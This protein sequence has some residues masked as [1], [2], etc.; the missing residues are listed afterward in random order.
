MA[1][2]LSVAGEGVTLIDNTAQRLRQNPTA[3]EIRFW[4]LIAPLRSQWHFRKQVRMGPYFVDF[5]SHPAK[6]VIEIDGDTHY[7]G[8]GPERDL[9]RDKALS[10]RG[11]RV[12]R[13]T[14]DE[15]MHSAD[16]VFEA[17]SRALQERTPPPERR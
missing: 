3:P 6:L 10:E 17:V 13:F 2:G 12:L 4:R 11:Y 15:V 5:A 16:G 7:V 8:T 14:N 9:I 1:E